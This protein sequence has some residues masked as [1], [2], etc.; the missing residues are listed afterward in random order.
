[1][2]Q[3]HVVTVFVGTEKC[4]KLASALGHSCKVRTI[5]MKDYHYELSD[6]E[7]PVVRGIWDDHISRIRHFQ[8]NGIKYV[9]VDNGYFARFPGCKEYFRMTWNQLQATKYEHCKSDRW[10]RFQNSGVKIEPWK[11]N[12]DGPIIVC[13]SPL[14]SIKYYG[15]ER[16]LDN[17]LTSIRKYTDREIIV[18]EKPRGKK[19]NIANF[20]NAVKDA[21][22]VVAHTSIA[23]VEAVMYGIPVVVDPKSCAAMVGVTKINQINNL[24][25]PDRQH[26]L[27]WLSYSQFSYG[28]MMRGFAVKELIR[29]KC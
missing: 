23:A 24:S 28:E 8:D 15:T 4:M 7:I 25:Y 11:I 18:R 12:K 22:C 14:Q 1:M 29:T 6:Y 5:D 16:W 13:P 20:Q 2:I 10:V 3:T 21:Y 17:T 9:S 27:N 19:L 26:W